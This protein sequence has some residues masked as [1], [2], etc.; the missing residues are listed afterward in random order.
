MDKRIGAQLYTIREFMKTIEDFDAS[1]KKIKDMGYA[2]LITMT[3]GEPND[4]VYRAG[5]TAVYAYNWGHQSYSYEYTKARINAQQSQDKVHC[6]PT[7]CVGYNDVAWREF[8]SPFAEAGEFG[9]LLSWIKS[10]ALKKYENAEE[11][12]KKKFV[13]VSRLS[14]TR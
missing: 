5:I 1:C 7:A 10:D 6:V 14:S 11:S 8:R 13:V 9:Q 3:S 2:G 4:E 12:W